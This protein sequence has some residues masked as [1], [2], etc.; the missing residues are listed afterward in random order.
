[1]N[2]NISEEIDQEITA[3]PQAA[4][5]NALDDVVTFSAEVC[6]FCMQIVAW[7]WWN[8][9]EGSSI[10]LQNA[11]SYKM[12]I[13]S[14]L[15]C[16]SPTLVGSRTACSSQSPSESQLTSMEISTLKAINCINK[17]KWNSGPFSRFVA[18]F[19]SAWVSITSLWTTRSARI[20]LDWTPI[21]RQSSRLRLLDQR[22]AIQNWNFNIIFCRIVHLSI[23]FVIAGMLIEIYSR[24]C[25]WQRSRSTSVAR[26]SPILSLSWDCSTRWACCTAFLLMKQNCLR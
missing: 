15:V 9:V 6:L 20:P 25:V 24:L 2:S 8:S 23:Y 13:S 21:L 5:I 19:P 14:S 22:Y 12:W 16:P 18:S 3:H 17:W 7:G 4:C 11:C 10:E 1:M 26:F